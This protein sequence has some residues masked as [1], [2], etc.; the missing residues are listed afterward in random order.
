MPT[1]EG[2]VTN[3]RRRVVR[4]KRKRSRRKHVSRRKVVTRKKKRVIRRTR[5]R[6]VRRTSVASRRYKRFHG[7][8]GKQVGKVKFVYPRRLILIGRAISVVYQPPRHSTKFFRTR[9]SKK[10]G[11]Y[12]HRFGKTVSIYT[13]ER[14][15]AAIILGGKFRVTD[16]LRG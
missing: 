12:I 3:P 6:P 11:Q 7:V 2:Y 1:G 16:W 5:K 9:K 13:T 14:G 4:R 10:A 8:P 15:D